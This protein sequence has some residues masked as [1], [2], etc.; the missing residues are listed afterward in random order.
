LS[1]STIDTSCGTSSFV[2][3]QPAATP[4]STTIRPGISGNWDDPTV[5]Q[6]G[7]G[8]QFEILPNNGILVI[9]FVFTPDGTGQTWLYSQGTYDPASNTV[10]LPTYVSVGPKFPPNYNVS[11]RH[12]TQWGTLKFTFTDCNHGTASWTSTAAGYPPSGSFPIARV[13]SI[14]GTTCP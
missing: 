11:D 14:A 6:E 8:F 7:H 12:L 5:G 10:T 2:S 13:T 3:T 4:L 9:W 1:L